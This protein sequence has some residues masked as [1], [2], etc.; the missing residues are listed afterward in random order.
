MTLTVLKILIHKNIL[1]LMVM[2]MIIIFMACS[3]RAV[4]YKILNKLATWVL[5]KIQKS[6]SSSCWQ[7][8]ECTQ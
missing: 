1:M 2:M 7:G 5:K 3:Q 4:W 8:P 6:Y